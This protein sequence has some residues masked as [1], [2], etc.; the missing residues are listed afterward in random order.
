METAGYNLQWQT[1]DSNPGLLVFKTH[2]G[3][4]ILDG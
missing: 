2:A 4:T 1:W 3:T